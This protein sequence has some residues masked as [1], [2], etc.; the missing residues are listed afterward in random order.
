MDDENEELQ[1][2]HFKSQ[3]E[4]KQFVIKAGKQWRQHIRQKRILKWKRYN[5]LGQ[6]YDLVKSDGEEANENTSPPNCPQ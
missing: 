6:K 3:E 1:S 2:S 5:F 4:N